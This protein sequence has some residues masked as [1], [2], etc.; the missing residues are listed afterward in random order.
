M[1]SR[2]ATFST[3]C[4]PPRDGDRNVGYNDS[5]ESQQGNQRWDDPRWLEK[6]DNAWQ[7]GLRHQQAWWREER[8]GQPPGPIIGGERLVASMLPRTVGSGPNLMTA[9]ARLAAERAIARLS[10]SGG[11][12]IIQEERLRR[13]LLS[14][15]PLCF[16]LFGYLSEHP[17]T[18]LPWV[19]QISP[20]AAEVIDVR[21]EW[22]PADKPLGGSAFDAFVEYALPGGR[23][24]FIGIECKYAE[25]LAK[26]QPK[27]ASEKYTEA[28]QAGP[29]T[30][31]A[32]TVLD[33]PRLRQFW[34]NQLLTQAVLARPEF[35]EGI[36][37]VVAC[38]A[39][40]SARDV[41]AEVRAQLTEPES[42]RFS[43]IE[44][45]VATV[46]GHQDW[47]RDFTKRYLAFTPIQRLL[48]PGDPR[49]N[50]TLE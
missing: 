27:P 14:S 41:T 18:L 42:L 1:P 44:E 38:G 45:V 2:T 12:G 3:H 35:D 16:N 6:S 49:K 5:M 24:G 7:R 23:R 47:A 37:V 19:R 32:E 43:S 9:E 50:P 8:L 25:N 15:Q 30:A 28:T 21:L 31:G 11:P 4:C 40:T 33:K 46:S 13:N 10:R 20:D 22:A 26:A 17:A 36:G 34:Y 29:W 48:T 39:D